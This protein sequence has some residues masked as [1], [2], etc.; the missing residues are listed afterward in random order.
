MSQLARLLP[1]KRT[2]PSMHEAVSSRFAPLPSSSS[3]AR[4]RKGLPT[5][6]FIPTRSRPLAIYPTLLSIKTEALPGQVQLR[7]VPVAG[8]VD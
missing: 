3:S 6:P 5:R 1:A 2:L 7:E 8:N 4:S